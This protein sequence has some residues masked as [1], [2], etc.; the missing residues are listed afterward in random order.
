MLLVKR[1]L[2]FVLKRSD[3]EIGKCLFTLGCQF[4]SLNRRIQISLGGALY[5]IPETIN[6]V[7]LQK[8]C[9]LESDSGGMS[10][11]EQANAN[12]F[13]VRVGL[14][15]IYK[16]RRK[17]GSNYLILSCKKDCNPLIKKKHAYI[18]PA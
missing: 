15:I 9:I 2:I 8:T 6:Y 5:N 1:I 13:L 4:L 10:D 18:S 17:K 14:I 7:I 12:H 11:S 3:C 16:K